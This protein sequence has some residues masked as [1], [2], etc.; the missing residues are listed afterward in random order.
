MNTKTLIPRNARLAGRGTSLDP[1]NRFEKASR[2]SFD[3]GWETLAEDAP[4]PPTI[5]I[6]DATRSIL[7][8][9][10]SP[11][12]GFD[13][14]LN[15]YRGCEHGCIYCYA[16]PTHAYLGFSAGLDF[17]TKLIFKPEAAALLE[18][19]LSR[20]SYVPSPIVVGSNTD[21]YQPVER[22][23]KLTRAVLEVLDRFNHPVSIITKSA[24]VL[25]DTDILQRM[26]ARHLARVHI[27]ITTLDPRLARAMEPRAASPTRRLDAVAGLTAAGIPVGVLA[28]P[29]I[30]GLNDAELERILEAAAR[31]GARSAHAILLRLPHELGALFEDWL[32]RTMPDRAAHILSLIRQTRD[33][34]L[35]DA[36]FGSRFKGTGPYASLLTA[37]FRRAAAQLGLSDAPSPLD[38]TAF[39]RPHQR[40]GPAAQLS[41]F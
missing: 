3:D 1:A 15:P 36:K 17:E 30:P 5:L 12:I 14:G 33:G 20:K 39:A 24:G 41:L 28:A 34:A 2:D 8:R 29:M 11:D 21:P 26:A 6:R 19:E 40:S 25:R 23:L 16:R 7:S 37:R 38:C 31:A 27:S 9:N 4:P 13:R 10:I 35:N 22:Q 32:N 18:R